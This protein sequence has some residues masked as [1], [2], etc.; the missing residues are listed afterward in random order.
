MWTVG[1]LLS[2][3]EAGLTFAEFQAADA[4]TLVTAREKAH[5][6]LSKASPH[7]LIDTISELPEV[8]SDIERRLLAGERP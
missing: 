3:N 5:L 4:A 8:I 6:K 7:Y 1:L 2:G